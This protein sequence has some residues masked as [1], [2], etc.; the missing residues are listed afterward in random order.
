MEIVQVRGAAMQRASEQNET[1]MLTIQG[2]SLEDAQIMCC[3][4]NEIEGGDTCRN[5]VSV[6][7]HAYDTCVIVGGSVNMLNRINDRK[8]HFVSLVLLLLFIVVFLLLQ[9]KVYVL[10]DKIGGNRL[11]VHV[12]LFYRNILKRSFFNYFLT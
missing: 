8:H 4:M 6:A 1:G 2:I 10:G 9:P 7:I 3:E 12:H 5:H 11:V